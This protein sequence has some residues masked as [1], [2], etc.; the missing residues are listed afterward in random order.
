V[1][2][3]EP[4]RRVSRFAIRDAI[5]QL[6]PIRDH[7][8]IVF[9]S[10][11]YDF[12][13]ETTR[14]LEFA[15]LCTFCV[16]RISALLDHTGKFRNRPRK[17]Y[18]DTGAILGALME[19]GYDSTPGERALRRLNEVHGRFTIA[20]ED[21]LYVL[22]S[23]IYA[24]ARWNERFGWRPWCEQERLGYFYFWRQIGERMK[25]QE[26][27]DDYA[28]FERFNRD[29]ERRH[30]RFTESNQRTGVAIR[31]ML[32]SWF[33]RWSAPLVR[34]AFYAMLDEPLLEAFGFP[35]PP[36]LFNWLVPRVIRLRGVLASWLR[37]RQR[38]AAPIETTA[39]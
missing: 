36:R 38:L 2:F 12:P 20:N 17:R 27:P 11:H 4:R 22:S 10:S 33:P 6:D 39:I 16:P 29:Y 24:T 23:L 37:A 9:L 14:A 30:Y 13:F 32:V 21:F 7:S 8:R 19:C 31:E 35:R 34:R 3:R 18:D 1:A 5:R 28:A 25:I 15:L 26:I